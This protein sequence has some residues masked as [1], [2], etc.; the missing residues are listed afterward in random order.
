MQGLSLLCCIFLLI[1]SL[2]LC[3]IIFLTAELFLS[4]TPVRSLAGLRSSAAVTDAAGLDEARQR[5]A[6]I[7]SQLRTTGFTSQIRE[8]FPEE[9]VGFD[10]PKAPQSTNGAEAT[11]APHAGVG[12]PEGTGGAL[13][14]TQGGKKIKSRHFGLDRAVITAIGSGAGVGVT[15]LYVDGFSAGTVDGRG[16]SRAVREVAKASLKPVGLSKVCPCSNIGSSCVARCKFIIFF[17]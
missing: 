5:N 1:S 2:L 9:D 15:G 6:V 16:A 10:F 7:H 13:H 11:G 8:K 14:I 12:L 4:K 17:R 3:S